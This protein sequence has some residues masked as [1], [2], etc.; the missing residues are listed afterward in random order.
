MVLLLMEK[1]LPAANLHILCTFCLCSPTE[2]E[3]NKQTKRQAFK[4]AKVCMC[5][6]LTYVG[7]QT[8]HNEV[9]NYLPTVNRR[10]SQGDSPQRTN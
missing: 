6:T 10:G 5:S 2:D 7:V 8:R 1:D 3:L 4:M 9:R